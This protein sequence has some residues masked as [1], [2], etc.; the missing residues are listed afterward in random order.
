MKKIL[1]IFIMMLSCSAIVYSQDV[2]SS[3]QGIEKGFK[4]FV[5]IG[6][7]KDF[8]V[9]DSKI[10]LL[11]SYGYQASPYVYCG[12]GLGLNY[13]Y[14]RI[15]D[16]SM[17]IFAHVRMTP[18]K[19]IVTPYVDLKTGYAF[20]DV[21]GFFVSPSIGIRVGLGDNVGIYVGI[22][23]SYLAETWLERDYKQKWER[24]YDELNGWSLKFGFDI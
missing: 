17:P 14:D 16:I 5:E 20:F 2:Q 23:Y 22:G 24:F 21:E 15:S 7:V 3:K 1:M 12:L 19:S 10:E 18:S 11:N 6:D 13:Y 4:S 8:I 9:K